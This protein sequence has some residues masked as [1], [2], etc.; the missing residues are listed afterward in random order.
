MFDESRAM[1]RSRQYTSPTSCTTS[2]QSISS[3]VRRLRANRSYL[4][5][6]THLS[7]PRTPWAFS[8]IGCGSY[9]SISVRQIETILQS[10]LLSLIGIMNLEAKMLFLGLDNAGK[11][12]LN[13]E[14]RTIFS[15][16]YPCRLPCL[17]SSLTARLCPA[18]PRTN[19]VLFLLKIWIKN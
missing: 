10:Y 17:E 13:C 2:L 3:I 4:E 8:S 5:P 19:Q 7:Q 18:D 9:F 16:S 15:N 6:V 12:K 11:V 14:N 1:P